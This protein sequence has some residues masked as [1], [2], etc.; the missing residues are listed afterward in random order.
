L[1]RKQDRCPNSGLVK[2]K[3]FCRYLTQRELEAAQTVPKGY[4]DCLTYSQAQD[5]LG[6][7]WTVDVIVL[8][9]KRS[10]NTEVEEMMLG[11]NKVEQLKWIV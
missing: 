6:D 3:D 4:T 5:V 9:L 7:G 10:F 11:K 8:I 1:T 2:H